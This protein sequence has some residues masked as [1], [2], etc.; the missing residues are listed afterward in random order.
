[1]LRFRSLIATF[2][3]RQIMKTTRYLIHTLGDQSLTALAFITEKPNSNVA[4]VSIL[5]VNLIR[6]ESLS[7]IIELSDRITEEVAITDTHENMCHKILI[8]NGIPN[9]HKLVFQKVPELI[10]LD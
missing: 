8:A 3:V 4:S 7:P 5:P 1:M 2:D 10:T 9:H 6:P